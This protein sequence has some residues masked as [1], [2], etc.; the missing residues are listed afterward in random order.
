[1]NSKE[2]IY[3]LIFALGIIQITLAI[4]NPIDYIAIILGFLFI[5]VAIYGLRRHKVL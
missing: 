5:G 1:M 4:Y 2:I 3:F